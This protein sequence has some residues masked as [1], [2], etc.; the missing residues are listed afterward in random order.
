MNQTSL[1][2]CPRKAEDRAVVEKYERVWRKVPRIRRN[3]N[4]GGTWGDG[5][6]GYTPGVAQKRPGYTPRIFAIAP[7]TRVVR[8]KS[9]QVVGGKGDELPRTAPLAEIARGEKE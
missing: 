8:G 2:V 4:E 5:V 7:P 6:R 1:N 3:E 9:A